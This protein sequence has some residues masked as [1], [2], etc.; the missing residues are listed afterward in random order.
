MS[1]DQRLARIEAMLAEM[2]DEM[3]TMRYE[4]ATK[5]DLAHNNLFAGEQKLAPEREKLYAEERKRDR[6]RYRWL[7]PTLAI[8]AVIGGLLGTTSFLALLVGYG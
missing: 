6:D 7:A 8:A 4:M 1:D 2:R 5:A 3:T